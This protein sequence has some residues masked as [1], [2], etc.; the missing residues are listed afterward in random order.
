MSI[1]KTIRSLGRPVAYYPSLAKPLGGVNQALLCGKILC[2]LDG[3]THPLG[4]VLSSKQIEAETGLTYRAQQVARRW[5]VSLGVLIET[6]KRIE[7][8]IYYRIDIDALQ[9]VISN[10]K[11]M[12]GN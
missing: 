12:G 7:H 11:K 10:H 2:D 4:V 1:S 6:P 3:V 8:K 5:L 9:L